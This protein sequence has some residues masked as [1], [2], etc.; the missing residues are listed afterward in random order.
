M[1]WKNFRRVFQSS[2]SHR[3]FLLRM[4]MAA[5][6]KP[7][8]ALELL[9]RNS[10]RTNPEFVVQRTEKLLNKRV[11]ILAIQEFRALIP[12][13][14]IGDKRASFKVVEVEMRWSSK[15]LLS[16]GVVALRPLVLLVD[17]RAEA[18]F[19]W[20]NHEFFKTHLLFVL[21]KITWELPVSH[22]VPDSGAFLGAERQR[23]DLLLL[24][25]ERLDSVHQV[26]RHERVEFIRR[27]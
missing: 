4:I 1:L 10:I 9:L 16:M 13:S 17:V 6:V 25:V 2:D 11:G 15:V 22:Q 20:V 24:F 8:L 21:V 27:W 18:G 12:I 26:A 7:L 23:V 5:E 14:V 19:V 3:L